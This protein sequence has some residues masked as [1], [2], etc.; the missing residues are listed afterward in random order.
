MKYWLILTIFLLVTSCFFAQKPTTISIG[1]YAAGHTD[2]LLFNQNETYQFGNYKGPAPLFVQIWHPLKRT[3]KTDQLTF[4]QLRNAPVPDSLKHIYSELQRLSDSSF[5][6]YNLLY[7]I[8][9]EEEIGYD[10]LTHSD[11]LE[12]VKLLPTFSY[13]FPLKTGGKF[14]VIVYHHGSQSRAD[15]NYL[16]AA[17]LASRGYVVVSADFHLPYTDRTYGSVPWERS[18]FDTTALATLTHFAENLA[19]S[20]PVYVIGH[21]WGA[22]VW[23]QYLKNNQTVDGFISLETTLEFKTDTAMVIDRWP[24]LYQTLKSGKGQYDL[25]I[26]LMAATGNDQPFPWFEGCSEQQIYCS[27]KTEFHHDSYTSAFFSRYFMREHL[28]QPDEAELE[29]QYQLYLKE[30]E[31]TDQYLRSISKATRWN[32]SKFTTDFFLTPG[33]N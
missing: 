27:P 16:M 31:M 23:W 20:Q 5:V 29:R 17:Y 25:P 24:E 13:R 28:P 26:L 21:S 12:E 10:G 11:L 4:G 14:P 32:F 6:E 2:T 9:T 8:D 30:L 22:Q 33:R 1:K 7:T 3:P 19:G 18:Y 15:E